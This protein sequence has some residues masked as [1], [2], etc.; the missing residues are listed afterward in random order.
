[1]SQDSFLFLSLHLSSSPTF[2]FNLYMKPL[3]KDSQWPR[4]KY[5]YII[6]QLHLCMDK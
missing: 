6:I 3:D 2:L 5:Q 1:M 4:V